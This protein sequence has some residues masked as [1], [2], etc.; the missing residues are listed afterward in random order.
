MN[1]AEL[2]RILGDP[3][4]F[5]GQAFEVLREIAH[6]HAAAETGGDS[7]AR[8]EARHLPSAH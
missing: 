7:Q 3:E 6:R 8:Q 5:Q 1:D 2:K 4:H